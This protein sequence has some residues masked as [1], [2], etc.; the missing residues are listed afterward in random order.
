MLLFRRATAEAHWMLAATTFG[1][2]LSRHAS[3][4]H[5]AIE[6]WRPLPV[7]ETILRAYRAVDPALVH[8]CPPPGYSYHPPLHLAALRNRFDVVGALLAHGADANV[9]ESGIRIGCCCR[10][11]A[12]NVEMAAFLLERGIEHLGRGWGKKGG[13]VY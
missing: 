12:G 10:P 1:S 5:V 2:H 3:S 6:R 11:A 13:V 7:I 4:L 9:R 8:G